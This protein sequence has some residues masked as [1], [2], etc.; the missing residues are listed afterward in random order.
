MSII[1]VIPAA[2][3]N[4]YSPLGDLAEWGYTTLLEWKISQLKSVKS[5]EHILVSTASS[6]AARVAKNAGVDVLHRDSALPLA[7]VFGSVGSSFKPDD[8]ILWAN[9]TSPFVGAKVYSGFIADYVGAAF[10]EDGTVTVRSTL[11]YMFFDGKPLGFQGKGPAF[12]RVDLPPMQVLTN[13]GYLSNASCM[14]K[15]KRAFGAKPRF[16]EVNWLATLEIREAV[17]MDLFSPLLAKY[18]ESET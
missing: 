1:A 16:Y 11:E 3:Q 18:F 14:A 2:S 7:D 8:H 9:P 5:I 4:R 15:R 6:E 10:P 13:G 17:Q 12:S